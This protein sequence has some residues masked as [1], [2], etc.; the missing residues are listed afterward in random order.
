MKSKLRKCPFCGS[1]HD[2]WRTWFSDISK[3]GPRVCLYH[4]CE[5]DP[6]VLGTVITVYG[7]TEEECVKRWNGN[8]KKHTSN[9]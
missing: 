2:N 3:D 6:E 9:E 4:Y 5:S 8:G 7:A 1:K